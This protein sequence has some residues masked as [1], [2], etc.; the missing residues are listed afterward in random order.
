MQ[1]DKSLLTLWKSFP[2]RT[3][4]WSW[5]CFCSCNGGEGLASRGSIR[6]SCQPP[7]QLVAASAVTA[8]R[9]KPGDLGAYSFAFQLSDFREHLSC[10][11]VSVLY[12]HPLERN[13]IFHRDNDQGADTAFGV[14]FK[15][16]SVNHKHR[17]KPTECCYRSSQHRWCLM[18]NNYL[19]PV[20]QYHAGGSKS[21]SLSCLDKLLLWK[22]SGSFSSCLVKMHFN[23]CS[24]CLLLRSFPVTWWKSAERLFGP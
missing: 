3:W 5:R 1:L 9:W 13:H 6:G 7:A 23:F 24:V 22:E 14:V 4:G 12:P 10:F 16:Q 17:A 11:Q 19:W 8:T 2:L 20:R 18:P 15:K 21:R